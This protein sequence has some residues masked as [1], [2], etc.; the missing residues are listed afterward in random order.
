MPSTLVVGTGMLL[1]VS[2]ESLRRREGL[3]GVTDCSKHA[4]SCGCLDL[5][6]LSPGREA[7]L[8]KHL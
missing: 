6:A 4:P 8:D 7:V 5:S 1:N 3:L 2:A